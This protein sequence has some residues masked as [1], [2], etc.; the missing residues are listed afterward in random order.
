MT[1]NKLISEMNKIAREVNCIVYIA[2]SGMK[3]HIECN[4]IGCRNKPIY[5]FRVIKH[6]YVIWS[7]KKHRSDFG[8][9]N[10]EVL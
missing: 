7:C 6:N 1:K 10:Y 8:A 5:K 9:E 4:V 3:H 2:S